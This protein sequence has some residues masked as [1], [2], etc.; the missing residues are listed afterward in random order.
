M[1]VEQIESIRSAQKELGDFKKENEQA[2]SDFTRRHWVERLDP[3]TKNC[4]HRYPWG[5]SAFVYDLSMPGTYGTCS[6]CSKHTNS[7]GQ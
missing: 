4:D 7:Y 5:D 2:L 3:L 6:I 1:T